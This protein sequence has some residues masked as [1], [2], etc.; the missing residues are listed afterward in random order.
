MAGKK[1]TVVVSQAQGKNPAKRQLEED[2][3][4]ALIMDPDID[5]SLVPNLYDMSQDHTGMLFLR[6]VRGDLVL[7]SWL[8]PRAARWILDRDGVSGQEGIT[9]LESEDEQGDDDDDENG[10][11]GA[12]DNGEH[13]SKGIG[14]VD[15]PNR[16]IYCIDLRCS[17]DPQEYLDEIRRIASEKSVQTVGLMDWIQG[18][19][20]QDQLQRYLH[21]DRML[22]AQKDDGNG[23]GEAATDEPAPKVK[24]ITI[25]RTIPVIRLSIV[26]EKNRLADCRMEC[27]L[28]SIFEG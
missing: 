14:S 12:S 27:L 11:N 28:S 7:L 23:N 10:K 22:A 18:S 20:K 9:L 21:P 15:V 17:A 13:E 4:A 6:S 8:Y 19:P 2:I 1:L 3:V 16:N 5:A 26:P 24:A 25:S